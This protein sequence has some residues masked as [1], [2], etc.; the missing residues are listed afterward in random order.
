MK[1]QQIPTVE[2]GDLF[3]AELR[4][5]IDVQHELCQ[6]A[7]LLEWSKLDEALGESFCA[8]TG[9]PAIRTR[10]MAGLMML[11]E[12]N[13]LSDEEVV[14]NWIENPYW[15]FFC[16]ERYFQHD[17]PIDPSSMTK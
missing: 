9:R 11:K 7:L 14:K 10:L 5:I 13:D 8:S 16:G 1:P 15:Q 6:L 4:S 17:L 12:I 3:R 2:T